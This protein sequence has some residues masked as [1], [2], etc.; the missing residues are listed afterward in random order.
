MVFVRRCLLVS[1]YLSDHYS[2][3]SPRRLERLKGVFYK[4]LT[5][6]IPCLLQFVNT[7]ESFRFDSA[8]FEFFRTQVH[9]EVY[10][11]EEAKTHA[12][13]VITDCRHL[14]GQVSFVAQVFNVFGQVFFEVEHVT[15]E[16]KVHGLPSEEL[17][18]VD[19]IEWCELLKSFS[20]VKTPRLNDGLVVDLSRCL[21][22]QIKRY[23]P[24]AWT[25]SHT[26][27]L[28]PFLTPVMA[29]TF[30]LTVRSRDSK[31]PQ[32]YRTSW[33]YIYMCMRFARFI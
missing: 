30:S 17:K 24:I 4:Q 18:E 2:E 31:H 21:S 10:P 7:I 3:S 28:L 14:D 8:K 33:T 15:L 22:P 25:V 6:S 1:D 27:A 26:A 12:F 19:C 23:S 9:I 11:H 32:L 29:A 13:S 16:H 5:F 20:N